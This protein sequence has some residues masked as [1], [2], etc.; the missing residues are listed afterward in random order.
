LIRKSVA[1]ASRVADATIIDDRDH[2]DGNVD[3]M[4]KRANAA[5]KFDAIELRQ[6]V[7]R[8][9]QVNAVVASVLKRSRWSFEEFEVQFA[10]DLPDDL[11]QQQP[12]AEQVVDDQHRIALRTY[13]GKLGNDPTACRSAGLHG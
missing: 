12:T 2:H 11:G 5:H 9:D 10:V 4:G 1:P 13:Q 6:F 7:V 8:Q 3:A